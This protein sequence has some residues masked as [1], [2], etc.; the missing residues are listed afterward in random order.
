MLYQN[1]THK[2]RI[3]KNELTM[4]QGVTSG[5]I[6]IRANKFIEEAKF[7]VIQCVLLLMQL[8]KFCL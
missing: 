4:P 6:Y 7:V 2:I 1:G 5:I 3:E 8:N